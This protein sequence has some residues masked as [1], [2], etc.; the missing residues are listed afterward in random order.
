[1]RPKGD[2]TAFGLEFISRSLLPRVSDGEWWL[3]QVPELPVY[4]LALLS[5]PGW[6]FAPPS[7]G[8]NDAAYCRLHNIGFP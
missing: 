6:S 5:D 2:A 4:V 8:A 7:L 3:S 1:M